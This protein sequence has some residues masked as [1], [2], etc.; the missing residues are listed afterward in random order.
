MR[1]QWTVDSVV[2]LL[3]CAWLEQANVAARCSTCLFGWQ[4]R[5]HG[6]EADN[7]TEEDGDTVKG[8][9]LNWP[10]LPQCC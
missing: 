8:L 2:L 7:V 10:P 6:L 1:G 9:R 4:L 3:T 5:R